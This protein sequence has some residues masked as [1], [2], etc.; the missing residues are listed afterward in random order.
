MHGSHIYLGGLSPVLLLRGL[1][2]RGQKARVHDDPVF[3][4]LSQAPEAI[5]NIWGLIRKEMLRHVIKVGSGT[6]L[7]FFFCSG[8]FPPPAKIWEPEEHLPTCPPIFMGNFEQA[9]S[10]ASAKGVGRS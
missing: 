1:P 9:C 3:I 7:S 2:G 4:T 10:H 6:S 8:L 5:E